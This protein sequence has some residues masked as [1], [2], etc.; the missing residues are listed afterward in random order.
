VGAI[1]PSRF[2]GFFGIWPAPCSVMELLLGNCE[3]RVYG[4]KFI[5]IMSSTLVLI[6][7][8]KDASWV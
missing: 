1:L 8:S 4:L 7:Y 2:V 3:D 6:P 5:F